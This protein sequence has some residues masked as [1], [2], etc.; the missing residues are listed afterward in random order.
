MCKYIMAKG[1]PFPFFDNPENVPAHHFEIL[2]TPTFYVIDR[3]GFLR[4][5]GAYDEAL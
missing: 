5:R 1:F 4:Y 3:K 2:V